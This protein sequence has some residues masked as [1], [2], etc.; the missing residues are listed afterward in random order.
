MPLPIVLIGIAAATGITGVSSGAVGAKKIHTAKQ[1]IKNAKS[2]YDNTKNDLDKFEVKANK[3][4]ENLGKL[5]LDTW[6]SFGRFIT[7]FEKIKN[8]PILGTYKHDEKIKLTKHDID[9]IKGVSIT[10]LNILGTGVLS[11]STGALAG[12]A[13]YGGTM[14]LGAASTGTKIALLSGVAAKNATLATLGGGSLATGG[15][16]IAGGTAVL[17]G[18]VAAPVLAVGGTLLAF[19]GNESKKK[20][21]KIESEVNEA[22]IAMINAISFLKK[23]D[24]VSSDMYKEIKKISDIYISKLSKLEDLVEIISDYNSFSLD[25]KR[26]LEN[27]VLLTKLLKELTITDILVKEDETQVINSENVLKAISKSEVTLFENNLNYNKNILYNMNDI[28]KI[29]IFINLIR[30]NKFDM[31]DKLLYQ[32]LDINN[33]SL[34]RVLSKMI[35]TDENC[36]AMNETQ[37]S[38]LLE[39]GMDVEIKLENEHSIK[40]EVIKSNRWELIEVLLQN[41]IH[42]NNKYIIQNYII[43]SLDNS[44]NED[45]AIR[46]FNNNNETILDITTIEKVLE[47]SNMEILDFFADINLVLDDDRLFH[48]IYNS[49]VDNFEFLLNNKMINVNLSHNQVTLLDKLIESENIVKVKLLMRNGAHVTENNIKKLSHLTDECIL[50]LI[51]NSMG[52][53]FESSN[54]KLSLIESFIQRKKW[55][56]IKIAITQ[57]N[58]YRVN[59]FLNK[60]TYFIINTKNSIDFDLLDK[61]IKSNNSIDKR[62]LRKNAV[63][64]L[65]LYRHLR[66]NEILKF[67]P[68]WLIPGYRGLVWWKM[69]LATITY[70]LII[71]SLVS[72]FT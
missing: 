45:F 68:L 36:Y 40:E 48:S 34:L 66:K 28:D 50:M 39:R 41:S 17:G 42:L 26:L 57:N 62:V 7:I 55:E 22:V 31:S 35:S 32:N 9:E 1:I 18:L 63:K 21:L 49:H 24:R 25:E 29:N 70:A 3:S 54:R 6:E 65:K 58:Q 27:T 19:K 20:A 5:K 52:I 11:A 61:I 67:N 64:N 14:A 2:I 4:L 38:Y 46:M 10:A 30:L 60:Y 56:F 13:A 71:K 43:N 59:Y 72:K 47:K 8:K 51:E 23:L 33:P 37:F 53:K 12:F 15:L 69:V 44:F 16:G